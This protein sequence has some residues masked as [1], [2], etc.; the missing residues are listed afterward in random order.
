MHK[1]RSTTCESYPIRLVNAMLRAL[2][3]EVKER[4]QLN[5]IEAAQHVDEPDVWLTNPKYCEEI[6]HAITGAQ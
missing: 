6:Y 4:Y 2:R 1:T 5:A 3:Q